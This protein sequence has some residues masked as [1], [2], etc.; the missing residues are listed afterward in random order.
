M[1][2]RLPVTE[3]IRL[4]TRGSV[5]ARTQSATVGNALAS[6]ADVPWREVLIRT[7]GDD[8]TTALHQPGRPGLFVSTLRQALLA[9]EVDVIVHSFKDLPSGPASGLVLA[10]VPARAD[11]RDALVS[12]DGRA[13]AALSPGSVVGT[14]SPRRAAALARMRPDLVIRPI[15]GNVDTRVAKVRSGEFD[16]TVLAVAGLTRIGREGEIA[17]ILDNLLPAPAQGAL[18]VECRV[19]DQR[20]RDWLAR[21]DD[22]ESHLTT[23]AEREVLVGIDAACT[24]AVAASA[25]YADGVLRLRAEL[26]DERGHATVAVEAPLAVDDLVGARALGL[27]AAGRLAGADDARRPV[28]LVR[29]EGN[30]ADAESLTALGVPAISDPYVQISARRGDPAAARLLQAL[31]EAAEGGTGMWVVASSPMAVPAWADAVGEDVLHAAAAAAS[32]GG[33]RGAATGARTAA[34]LRAMGLADVVIP[35]A[36]SARDLVDLMGAHEPARALFPCGSLALRTLPD[37][38]RE[39]GWQVE[40]GVVYDTSTVDEVPGSSLLV[41]RSAV[42]A[43]VLRSPSAVRAFVSFVDPPAAVAVVCAGETTATAARAVGLRVD[44]VAAS[45]ASADV[46]RAVA[47]L[48][49]ALS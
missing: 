25:G 6:V 40:E 18:A 3:P 39:R 22:P 19:D 10:A 33:V 46:A 2:T 42:S 43:V 26:T 23:A 13:L 30:D 45:P 44:A 35:A 8:T 24:T 14:S 27:A 38:L 15:R 28:L 49:D 32:A 12:R 5:L 37:G 36:A 41:E 7:P 11:A 17:E 21:L 20:V 47:G 16:A 48:L 9:G 4:G 1:S 29:S 31:R 34:T